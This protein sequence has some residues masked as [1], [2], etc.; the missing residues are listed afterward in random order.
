MAMRSAIFHGALHDHASGVETISF[1]TWG[2]VGPDEFMRWMQQ[3][4]VT[5]GRSLLRAKGVLNFAGEH[6]RFV[7]QGVQTVLDGDVQGPWPDGPRQSRMVLIGRD[8]GA[9]A[10]RKGW[11]SCLRR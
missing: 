3:V 8:L 10:L 6:R 11:E 5:R 7:F 2:E 4:V 1:E 9:E